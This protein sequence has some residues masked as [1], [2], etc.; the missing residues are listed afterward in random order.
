MNKDTIDCIIILDSNSVFT[1][2]VLEAADFH[3]VFGNVFTNPAAFDN[4]GHLTVKN[5]HAHSCNR[6]LKNLCKNA[7]FLEFI[8]KQLQKEVRLQDCLCRRLWK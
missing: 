2:W 5:C 6:F 8:D 4:S 3:D 7:V 1:G